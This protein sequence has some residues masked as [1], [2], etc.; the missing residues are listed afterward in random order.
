MHIR[1]NT[2]R[3]TRLKRWKVFCSKDVKKMAYT[4]LA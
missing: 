4:W 3:N 2:I 1:Q